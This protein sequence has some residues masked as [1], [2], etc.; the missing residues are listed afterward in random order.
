MVGRAS[1]ACLAW[2]LE[3]GEK[4]GNLDVLASST[5]FASAML[6]Q[7]SIRN[8]SAIG[9]LLAAV[10]TLSPIGGQASLRIMTIGK[11]AVI[12]TASFDY[13]STY[14][15]YSDW[16]SASG[17][18]SFEATA[19]GLYL[20]SLIAPQRMKDSPT[21]LWDNVKIPML[22]DIPGWTESASDTDAWYKVPQHNVS[23]SS[24]VGIPVSGIAS[25][26]RMATSNL[27]TSYWR[28]ECPIVERGSTCDLLTIRSSLAGFSA[29]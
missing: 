1:K 2:R 8:V 19:T 13:L 7:V 23:Y 3:V 21:D 6:A 28:L 27:E 29:L 5:T 22:E 9:C 16:H 15:S 25:D 11:M 20:A 4:L 17:G 14:N 10:W 12:N 26:A 24:L 18:G